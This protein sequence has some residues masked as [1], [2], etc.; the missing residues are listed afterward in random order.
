MIENQK[1]RLLKKRELDI[2]YSFSRKVLIAE[3][4]LEIKDKAQLFQSEPEEFEYYLNNR[5]KPKKKR[6]PKIEGES[7]T[8][9]LI[10]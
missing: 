1:R 4:M 6:V 8:E 9:L 2:S 3:C 7:S 5:R 10:K